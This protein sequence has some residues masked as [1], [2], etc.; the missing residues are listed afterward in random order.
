M[1]GKDVQ[2]SEVRWADGSIS[3]SGPLGVVTIDETECDFCGRMFPPADRWVAWAWAPGSRY[4]AEVMWSCP[5]C[6]ADGVGT[7]PPSVRPLDEC[8]NLTE[9][10]E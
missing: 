1:S 6:G 9:W 10:S 2:A 4:W 7:Q 8:D 5:T 3:L